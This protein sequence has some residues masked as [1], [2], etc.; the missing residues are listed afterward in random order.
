[1]FN[2]QPDPSS[3]RFSLRPASWDFAWTSR[4]DKPGWSRAI[5]P[6]IIPAR[7]ADVAAFGRKPHFNQRRSA[8]TP[9][10]QKTRLGSGRQ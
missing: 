6:V 3:L 8:E 5:R 2:S 10:R 7:L 4:R 9:L 1:L